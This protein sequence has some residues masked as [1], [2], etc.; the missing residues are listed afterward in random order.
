LAKPHISNIKGLENFEGEKY[1]TS[2]WPHQEVDFRG[3][4][5]GVIGTGSSGVQA[6]TAIAKE[7]EHLTVFQ[8][9]PQYTF[10][11]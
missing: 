8:R 10:P 7:T 9:T 1:H 3:K 5:V 2:R 4:R 11:V 6:I